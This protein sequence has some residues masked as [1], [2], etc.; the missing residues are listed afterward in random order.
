[1]L[2]CTCKS[3]DD[4]PR[5]SW[6]ASIELLSPENL[7]LAGRRCDVRQVSVQTARLRAL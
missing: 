3:S 4:L 7:R 5:W 6:R 2:I 1:M